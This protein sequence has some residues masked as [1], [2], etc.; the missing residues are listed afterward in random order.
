ML[1]WHDG[2]N[3]A[4][5]LLACFGGGG[6]LRLFEFPTV[7]GSQER[8]G[9]DWTDQADGWELLDTGH[10]TLGHWAIEIPFSFFS[11]PCLA[12]LLSV[13]GVFCSAFFYPFIVIVVIII[14]ISIIIVVVVL[15]GLLCS[16]TPI[17]KGSRSGKAVGWLGFFFFVPGSLLGRQ[18]QE[19]NR[20][21]HHAYLRFAGDKK[22]QVMSFFFSLRRRVGL[23]Y[24]ACRLKTV[25]LYSRNRGQTATAC[26]PS[27]STSNLNSTTF[28]NLSSN[29]ANRTRRQP[30]IYIYPFHTQPTERN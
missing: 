19:R 9:L 26:I 7:S 24:G 27:H 23:I 15:N 4:C 1:P 8:T 29:S 11:L 18:S 6:G 30:E 10:W 20:Y 5:C 22:F 21:L 12:L 17:P 28:A 2:C 14:T 25:S 13:A 16:N 3:A